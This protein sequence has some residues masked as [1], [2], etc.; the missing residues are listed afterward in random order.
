MLHIQAPV[1]IKIREGIT[2]NLAMSISHAVEHNLP[3]SRLKKERKDPP[4]KNDYEVYGKADTV[5]F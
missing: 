4:T 3:Q 5:S 2:V 1:L